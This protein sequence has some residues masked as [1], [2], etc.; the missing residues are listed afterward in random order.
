MEILIE[1]AEVFLNTPLTMAAIEEAGPRIGSPE[2]ERVRPCRCASMRVLGHA[3][4]DGVSVQ[5]RGLASNQTLGLTSAE[6]DRT[7]G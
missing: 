2:F 6:T 3:E 4:S 5:S 1:F 7:T